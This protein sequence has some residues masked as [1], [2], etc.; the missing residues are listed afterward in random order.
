MGERGMYLGY[1]LD[2][3]K[4]DQ[5]LKFSD[6]IKMDLREIR[7]MVWTGLLRL[8]IE[9]LVNTVMNLRGSI[10]CWEVIE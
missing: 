9:S 6:I 1:W 4:E 2:S 7:W 3:Q 8:R 10:K 5:H